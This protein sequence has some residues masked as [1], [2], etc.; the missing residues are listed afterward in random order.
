MVQKSSF[1]D[2]TLAMLTLPFQLT[3]NL[4]VN[5]RESVLPAEKESPAWEA[6]LLTSEYCVE[7]Y[8]SCYKEVNDDC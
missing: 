2:V 6:V 7:S 8:D 4:E 5:S 3:M 1:V